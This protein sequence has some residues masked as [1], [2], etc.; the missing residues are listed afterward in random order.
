MV[1]DKNARASTRLESLSLKNY[2]GFESLDLTL[3]PNLTVIVA[4]NGSGKTATL[5][6]IAS[7]WSY[8][9]D[10]ALGA[11]P[12]GR[13]RTSDTRRVLS[14][15]GAMEALTPTTVRAS[16][17]VD[18][19]EFDL[20]WNFHPSGRSKH[21]FGASGSA[22]GL[23]DAAATLR[24]AVQSFAVGRRAVAPVLPVVAHYGTARLWPA[25]G[26]PQIELVVE[27]EEPAV[28]ADLTSRL[29]GYDGCLAPA[30]RYRFFTEWFERFSREAQQ[31]AATQR[32][33][34]HNPVPRL[35]AVKAAVDVLLR[36][37]GWHSLEWDFALET[38][39]ASHPTYG[40]L[41]V[42]QLSDG[43][44]NTLGLVADLAHRAA[45]LNP[46]FGAD[47]ARLTPGVVLIDEVDLHL[48]PV[49]QQTVVGAL[50]E[51]FPLVQFI[52]TTHSP[53]VLSTVP[54]ACIRVIEIAGH[55]A[56]AWTPGAQT[57]GVESATV[58]AEV[59]GVDPIPDVEEARLLSDYR[60]L[61]ESGLSDAEDAGQLRARLELHFGA[62]H[63]LI[64]ECD[65]LIRVERF[66]RSLPK[67][68]V[69]GRRD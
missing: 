56:R 60:A 31:E 20:T 66:K 36:P 46:Q 43:I 52:V 65:R 4:T 62:S 54:A 57:L 26:V 35:E 17:L 18:G 64:L 63:H 68:L 48:H 3:H 44:R 67:D 22:Q 49:W 13:Y 27:D 51:A 16:G 34:P 25:P 12:M 45:R 40:R 61:I 21:S 50:R 29:A 42:T 15:D 6:A 11:V 23:L 41:P 32:P 33:S 28:S 2:R 8:F 69:P 1:D 7:C 39:V 37:T 59:M 19:S 9:V 5:D 30:P 53:Q 58:L 38:V 10:A 24:E 47:A 14:V 55:V